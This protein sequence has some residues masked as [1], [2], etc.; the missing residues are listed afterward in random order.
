MMRIGVETLNIRMH[1]TGYR[2]VRPLTPADDA[3]RRTST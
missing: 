2:V 3:V 1:L